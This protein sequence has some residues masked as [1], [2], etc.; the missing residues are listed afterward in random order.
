VLI[1]PLGKLY[2]G[3]SEPPNKRKNLKGSYTRAR[4]KEEELPSKFNQASSK[5]LNLRLTPLPELPRPA[6]ASFLLTVI[7]STQ[8]M[9]ILKIQIM[10]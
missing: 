6:R 10:R 1:P 7:V 8:F 3:R 9:M 2:S 4:K 5:P